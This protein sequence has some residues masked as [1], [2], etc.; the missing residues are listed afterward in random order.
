MER[1]DGQLPCLRC[2][3]DDC[4]VVESRAIL[5]YIDASIGTDESKGILD[6]ASSATLLDDLKL[7]PAFAKF[8][9][10][11]D[12]NADAAL[13]AALQERLSRLETI[14]SSRSETGGTGYVL[15]TTQPTMADCCLAPIVCH[16]SATLGTLKGIS[17]GATG[18]LADL[19]AVQR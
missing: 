9:K 6:S 18:L 1:H 8:C 5:E 19:P 14:L 7:F 13:L 15:G 2:I 10:N 4:T 3:P 16:M 17:F 11:T 12:A